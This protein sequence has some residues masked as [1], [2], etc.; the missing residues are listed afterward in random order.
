MRA[1]DN[2]VGERITRGVLRIE[3]G[4][5]AHWDFNDID[6]SAARNPTGKV[7]F[8]IEVDGIRTYSNFWTHGLDART[9]L[10]NPE[11]PLGNCS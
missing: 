3:I 4:G 8:W 5:A 2:R 9:Y 1:I 10:P 11:A 7:H 6:V